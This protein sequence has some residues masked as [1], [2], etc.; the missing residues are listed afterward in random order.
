[1]AVLIA[2]LL[3]SPATLAATGWSSPTSI[4][5]PNADLPSV[6][7]PSA[8]FCMAVDAASPANLFSYNGSGW[9]AAGTI[10]GNGNGVRTISCASAS[11]CA[12]VDD[13]GNAFTFNGSSWSAPVAVD[14]G[15]NIAALSCPTATF[16]AA[17]D[18]GGN[19]FTYNNGTW[20]VSHQGAAG[21]E[22]NFFAM[23]CLSASFCMAPDNT[24]YGDQAWTYNGSA[25]TSGGQDDSTTHPVESVSCATT[26]F[27]VVVDSGGNEA[28][29]NGSG[30]SGV[31]NVDGGTALF[32]VSCQSASFCAAVGE[33]GTATMF[34]GSSWSPPSTIDTVNGYTIRLNSVS[35]P[36][37]SFCGA[38]DDGG[39]ALTYSTSSSSSSGSTSPP[40]SGSPPAPQ[41]K[42]LGGQRLAGL[43]RHGLRITFSCAKVACKVHVVLELPPALARR[44]HFATVGSATFVLPSGGKRA[45]HVQLSAAA[46]RRLRGLDR[47][48]LTLLATASASGHTSRPTVRRIVVRR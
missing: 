26:S 42:I 27:C 41:L 45:V 33:N 36:T 5:S 8:T 2:G 35:C 7:C 15:S 39:N 3:A 28:T 30:W 11:F 14:P 24:I 21:N 23:S 37:A 18:N 25:W 31:V 44:F 9:S 19:L 22:D 47:L 46:R 17:G 13:T 6:S 29:Y 1:M 40:S 48:A 20:G 10:D 38:V 16:C 34:N 43:L 32:S 12:A 4:D